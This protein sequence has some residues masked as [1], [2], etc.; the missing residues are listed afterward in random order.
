MQSCD[1][2]LSS[3][4]LLHV[5]ILVRFDQEQIAIHLADAVPLNIRPW[6]LRLPADVPIVFR[7]KFTLFWRENLPAVQDA[8]CL[9]G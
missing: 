6:F 7:R 1:P 9:T 2:T 4:T 8:Y 3:V 5:V